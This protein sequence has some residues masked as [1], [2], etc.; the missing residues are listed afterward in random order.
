LGLV[1]LKA[2]DFLVLCQ[3]VGELLSQVVFG[4][5]PLGQNLAELRWV[6]HGYIAFTTPAP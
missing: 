1:S 3:K 6:E 4:E 5:I 2:G